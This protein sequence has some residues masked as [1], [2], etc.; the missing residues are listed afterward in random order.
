MASETAG[1]HAYKNG[2]S[3]MIYKNLEDLPADAPIVDW[4]GCIRALLH[5]HKVEKRQYG[6]MV[7]EILEMQYM[8]GYRRI[9]GKHPW[10]CDELEKVASHFGETISQV[11]GPLLSQSCEKLETVEPA[12]LLVN[13]IEVKCCASLGE[14]LTPPYA[15]QLVAI[16][17]AGARLIVQGGTVTMPAREVRE[18]TLP[19][20]VVLQLVL[21]GS[22]HGI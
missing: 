7:S 8:A 21:R 18:L 1:H 3:A 22:S 19:S 6:K 11:L 12:L 14:Q 16:G 13:S 4:A 5:R 10:R 20:S 9:F 2:A 17:A 15:D